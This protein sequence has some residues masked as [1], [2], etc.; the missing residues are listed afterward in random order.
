L[1]EK[2]DAVTADRD[3]FEVSPHSISILH[4][5]P[6]LV[7]I[8]RMRVEVL[9]MSSFSL[10]PSL[11]R[12]L[13][14]S[15]FLSLSL[16]SSLAQ[17]L[18][19]S[20]TLALPFLPLSR[21]LAL[22]PPHTPSLLLAP[23]LSTQAELSIKTDRL[24]DTK[25]ELTDIKI[26]AGEGWSSAQT[27]IDSLIP[28]EDIVIQEPQVEEEPDDPNDF[29]ETKV[30]A[31]LV[32]MM[33]A[34]TLPMK[35]EQ[36]KISEHY[37][38]VALAQLYNAWWRKAAAARDKALQKM[39]GTP[40]LAGAGASSATP[41]TEAS[42]AP[43]SSQQPTSQPAPKDNDGQ[44]GEEAL[45]A[46]MAVL[47]FQ[48][49]KKIYGINQLAQEK[50]KEVIACLPHLSGTKGPGLRIALFA[51]FMGL[52]PPE[53]SM[54]NVT[55]LELYLKTLAMLPLGKDAMAPTHEEAAHNSAGGQDG[56]G[57]REALAPRTMTFLASGEDDKIAWLP[58][59]TAMEMVKSSFR[60]HPTFSLTPVTLLLQRHANANM[61]RATAGVRKTAGMVSVDLLMDLLIK[62]HIDAESRVLSQGIS[63]FQYLTGIDPYAPPPPDPLDLLDQPEELRLSILKQA[64]GKDFLSTMK[65][66]LGELRKRTDP[67]AAWHCYSMMVQTIDTAH[68]SMHTLVEQA[69]TDLALQRVLQDADAHAHVQTGRVPSGASSGRA[70]SAT[71]GSRPPSG[72]GGG[73]GGGWNTGG[74]VH[75]E[76]QQPHMV[77]QVAKV[78]SRL[79]KPQSAPPPMLVPHAPLTPRPGQGGHAP[80]NELLQPPATASGVGGGGKLPP[81]R[82]PVEQTRSV[83]LSALAGEAFLRGL[84]GGSSLVG[85]SSVV[86][87][88]KGAAAGGVLQSPRPPVSKKLRPQSA[89]DS[90][91]D[92]PLSAAMARRVF[93]PR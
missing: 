11:S 68:K 27:R 4:S 19:P 56:A 43:A 85:P 12:C 35:P 53:L 8:D 76:G 39:A 73:G 20:L 30:V 55:H 63:P 75:A 58:F 90:L 36:I 87:G 91:S 10:S 44:P 40:L 16:P 21:S 81:V 37:L 86:G 23:P 74:G 26:R 54:A 82:L 6:P 49:A 42:F 57:P 18:S 71:Q 46:Q 15:P 29:S 83:K 48:W 60:S 41:A 13:P 25:R 34:D 84:T 70:P 2:I 59:E 93:T 67:G 50:C 1:S 65:E 7:Q 77:V 78:A 72:G 3:Y 31:R 88:S 80:Q 17:H 52:G 33:R 47:M 66:T 14:C 62:N 22:S 89:R 24:A 45:D 69:A 32:K 92:P 9:Y 38:L 61:R 64:F 51:T 28:K 79:G 5:F